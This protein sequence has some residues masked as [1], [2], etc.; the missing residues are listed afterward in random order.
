MSFTSYH[1]H[2]YRVSKLGPN[3]QVITF[4]MAVGSA[5]ATE[6]QRNWEEEGYMVSVFNITR[7]RTEYVTGEELPDE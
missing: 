3:K 4:I 2:T 1:Q 6:Q 7:G 5:K